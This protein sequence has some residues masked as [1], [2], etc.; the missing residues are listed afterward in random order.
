MAIRRM[1]LEDVPKIHEIGSNVDEFSVSEDS[2]HFW[3]K[4]ILERLVLSEHD[5]ALVNE[6]D[7]IKG[8]LI[9]TYHPVTKKATIENAWVNHEFKHRGCGRKLMQE[10]EKILYERGCQSY[11]AF[12]EIENTPASNMC[13]K[14]GYTKG[15]PYNWMSKVEK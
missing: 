2:G 15:K 3:S 8:Y 5:V 6:D 14:Q 10:A 9:A 4:E 11:C 7:G 13:V 12:V 1:S